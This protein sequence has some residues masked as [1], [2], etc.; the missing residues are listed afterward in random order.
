MRRERKE[1]KKERK[2]EGMGYSG[3]GCDCCRRKGTVMKEKERE[4]DE[5]R[6]KKEKKREEKGK[7]WDTVERIV[8]VAE[9]KEQ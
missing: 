4:C 5:G 6:G 8:S 9:G 3:K 1:E 7:E 2:T